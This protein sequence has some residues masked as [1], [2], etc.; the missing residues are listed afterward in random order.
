ML[1]LIAKSL[2]SI[3]VM[4]VAWW[5]VFMIGLSQTWMCAI[6]IATLFL[7]LVSVMTR[8]EDRLFEDSRVILSSS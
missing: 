8:V 6:D 5:S 4:L 3:L 1:Y 2:A 7:M